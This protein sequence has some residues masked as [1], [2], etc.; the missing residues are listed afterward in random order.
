MINVDTLRGSIEQAF[1][2]AIPGGTM[3]SVTPAQGWGRATSPEQFLNW[4]GSYKPPQQF[5]DSEGW[6]ANFAQNQQNNLAA[7]NNWTNDF[8]K[9]Q[10]QQLAPP[11]PQPQQPQTQPQQSAAPVISDQVPQTIPSIPATT[12]TE[13]TQPVSQLQQQQPQQL[14]Y[15]QPQVPEQEQPWWM[16]QNPLAASSMMSNALRGSRDIQNW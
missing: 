1:G 7:L 11:Q 5:G 6:Q 8:T 14:Q 2:N 4:A 16:T 10:A 15:Q 9:M 3:G 12:V 13:Q